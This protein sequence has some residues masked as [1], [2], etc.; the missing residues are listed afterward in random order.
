MESSLQD[1]YLCSI[2]LDIMATLTFVMWDPRNLEPYYW[3]TQVFSEMYTVSVLSSI[4]HP[5]K[6][7][8]ALCLVILNLALPQCCIRN[9]YFY[10]EQLKEQHIT[11]CHQDSSGTLQSSVKTEEHQNRLCSTWWID[12]VLTEK[13]QNLRFVRI[14]FPPTTSVF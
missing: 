4:A 2:K 14:T 6:R 5:E 12:S 11:R 3:Y 9:N 1:C 13:A 8:N 10:L 7:M